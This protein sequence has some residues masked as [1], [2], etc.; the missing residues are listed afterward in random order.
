MKIKKVFSQ[1]AV[2][3]VDGKE[4]KVA[5]GKGVG[6]KKQQ[7]DLIF[8]KDIE[9]LFVMEPDEQK[10][11]QFLLGQVDDKYFLMAEK[12]INHAETVLMEK[13]NEHLLITLT[14]HISFVA[15]NIENGIIIK[16]KLLKEIEVLYSEEFAIAQWA[17]DYLTH[18]LAIPY[19][20][21][22]AGLIAI[23][24]HGA[25][26]G[27]PNRH[28]SIREVSIIADIIALI[29]SE[30]EMDV[31]TE[32]MA[33]NY[34]RLVNHLRL[35]LERFQHSNFASLDIEIIDMIKQKYAQS[36]EISK[37]IKFF[38]IKNYHISITTEELGYIALHIERLRLS[39]KE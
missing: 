28:Q 12:I 4:E 27:E 25:R 37:K 24:I 2:L 21:N 39:K 38:L 7:N 10:K 16:N 6:F 13:L 20:F 22:E 15:E 5:I 29:E 11:L 26:T 31:H 3:V 30:L 18:N 32:D 34:T 9:R 14:D 17:V 23:H 35:V 19:S 1:N 33:L 8:N 36:Y